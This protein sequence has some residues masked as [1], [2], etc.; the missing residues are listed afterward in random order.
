MVSGEP[1]VFRHTCPEQ[2]GLGLS[3]SEIPTIPPGSENSVPENS[4]CRRFQR[5]CY[6]WAVSRPRKNTELGDIK[7]MLTGQGHRPSTQ[8]RRAL[9]PKDE[10]PE[11]NFSW[12]SEYGG[13]LFL[14][15]PTTLSW[16]PGNPFI[17]PAQTSLQPCQLDVKLGTHAKATITFPSWSPPALPLLEIHCLSA[18]LARGE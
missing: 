1:D 16:E 3:S 15:S 18:S 7:V 11:T 9:A 14:S 5:H 2:V 17:C 8:C 13:S 4:P 12:T 10:G 6:S